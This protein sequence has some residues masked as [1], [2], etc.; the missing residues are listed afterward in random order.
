M[1]TMPAA[2]R[3]NRGG[4]DG[5]S[6]QFVS[7]RH[8]V[9]AHSARPAQLNHPKGSGLRRAAVLRHF[10]E[11]VNAPGALDDTYITQDSAPVDRQNMARSWPAPARC[12]H[13]GRP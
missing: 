5:R 6:E 3:D 12:G 7:S 4:S 10:Q 8:L 2:S 13:S 11:C 1:S 9:S